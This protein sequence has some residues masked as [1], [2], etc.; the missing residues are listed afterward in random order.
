MPDR[1]APRADVPRRGGLVDEADDLVAVSARDIVPVALVDRAIGAAR[2]EPGV[3]VLHE[4]EAM[5]PPR[6]HPGTLLLQRQTPS[7][8]AP[9]MRR[10]AMS[11]RTC[12][13]CGAHLSNTKRADATYCT[14]AC[15]SRH[16]WHRRRD[17]IAAGRITLDS[18]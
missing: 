11:D 12:P 8:P 1:G 14:R 6:E 3:L 9:T 16:T 13:V 17:F 10:A 7:V 15:K 18:L 4:T 5:T 2:F